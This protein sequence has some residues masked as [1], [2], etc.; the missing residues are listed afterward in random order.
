[1]VYGG[2]N[3]RH[4]GDI[5]Q[6]T[7]EQ[8]EEWGPGPFDI[9]LSTLIKKVHASPLFKVTQT[10]HG[11]SNMKFVGDV[12]KI[13]AQQ[14]EAW[15]PFDLVIGGSPCNDLSAANPN[16]KGIYGDSGRLFFEFYRIL[17]DA[18]PLPG[19][20]RYLLKQKL[21]VSRLK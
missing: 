4:I 13:T 5:C 10:H 2:S 21:H 19:D 8:I 20:N 12:C 11:A 14:I 18:S 1:M 6:I 15:G 3:I 17:R 16:R 7:E 9:V